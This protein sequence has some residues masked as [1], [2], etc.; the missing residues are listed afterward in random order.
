MT[1]LYSQGRQADALPGYQRLR[2]LS[3]GELGIEPSPEL[4]DLEARLL[5]QEPASTS[6]P[7]APRPAPALATAERSRR[8]S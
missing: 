3:V 2:D 5:R 4:R 6:G 1:A 7:A 8:A